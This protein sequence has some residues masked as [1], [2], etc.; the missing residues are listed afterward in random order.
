MGSQRV[1]YNLATKPQHGHEYIKSYKIGLKASG[2]IFTSSK[3]KTENAIENQKQNTGSG[4]CL[5]W[6]E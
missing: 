2:T 1:G 6:L 3:R 5:G 4:S